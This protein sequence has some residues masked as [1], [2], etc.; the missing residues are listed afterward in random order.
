M[1]RNLLGWLLVFVVVRGLLYTAVVPPWQ[2]PDEPGHFEY[3]AL[4]YLLGHAPRSDEQLPDLTRTINASAQQQR[5]ELIYPKINISQLSAQEPPALVGPREAGYQNPFYYVLLASVYALVSRQDILIQ[6]YGL[7]AMSA[8]LSAT[9]VLAAALTA[10]TLFP[11]DHFLQLAVPALIAFWPTQTY[12]AAHINN[13]NLA[14]A[15]AAWAMFAAVSTL[16]YSLSLARVVLLLA[17]AGLATQIKGTTLFL[18]PLLGLVVLFVLL[19]NLVARLSPA[20]QRYAVTLFKGAL[21]VSAVSVG[22]ILLWPAAAGA[23][24]EAV[25]R[26]IWPSRSRDWIIAML[27]TMAEGKLWM[28]DH[29]AANWAELGFIVKTLW[30]A[31]G[32]GDV[33]L[34]DGWY[35]LAAALSGMAILGLAKAGGQHIAGPSRFASWQTQSLACLALA[36]PLAWAPLLARMI[37]LPFATFWHGRSLLTLLIP[38]SVFFLLG[39]KEMIPRRFQALSIHG[40]L[41]GLFLLDAA[42]LSLT[43]IFYYYK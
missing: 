36:I 23:A 8:V 15:T 38:L 10:R 42:S 19:R 21:V 29:L 16:R 24:R 35:W 4:I 34:A 28:P 41:A 32:W 13:D 25:T 31:F 2:S 9:T 6:Y 22:I 33:F 3:A 37:F 12:I 40:L 43:L 14:T 26:L 5:F 30:A 1:S 17:L 7:A 20:R 11:T 39:L 27:A 18:L